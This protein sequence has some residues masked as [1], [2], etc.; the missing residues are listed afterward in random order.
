MADEFKPGRLRLKG[1][2]TGRV[3]KKKKKKALK[4]EKKDDAKTQDPAEG[5]GD[6]QGEEAPSSPKPGQ[7]EKVEPRRYLTKA[8]IEFEKRKR[9]RELEK[10]RRGEYKSHKQKVQEF[11]EGLS[12]LSE[13]HDM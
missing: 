5:P 13:H 7:E 11:N 6:K 3:E 12:R 8:Q 1:V 10:A 4:K 9:E 2:D